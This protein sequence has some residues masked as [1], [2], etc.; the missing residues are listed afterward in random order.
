[1][2]TDQ[3]LQEIY[4]EYRALVREFLPPTGRILKCDL[5]NEV[6][7]GF[8][9]LEGVGLTEERTVWLEIDHGTCRRARALFPTRPV[10]QGDIRAL[11]FPDGCFAGVVDLSTIDHVLPDE[12]PGV[13]QEYHRVLGAGG[14]LILVVWVS[15]WQRPG[16]RP[17][18]PAAQYYL[19]QEDLARLAEGFTLLAQKAL[20][21]ERDVGLIAMVGAKHAV[22]RDEA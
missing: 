1:M 7:G 16:P 22:G 12:M 8:R 14:R 15:A 19:P 10:V 17:W 21:Q 18:N 13:G 2:L 9:H 4:A 11:P 5:Y 3:K 6:Q 20:F